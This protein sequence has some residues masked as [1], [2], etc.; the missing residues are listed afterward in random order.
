MC[1]FVYEKFP[2]LL[3]FIWSTFIIMMVFRYVGMFI[4]AA[5]DTG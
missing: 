4:A 3:R 2:Y 5:C 1:W